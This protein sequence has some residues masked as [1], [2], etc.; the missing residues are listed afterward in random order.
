MERTQHQLRSRTPQPNQSNWQ[1]G[2]KALNGQANRSALLTRTYRWPSVRSQSFCHGPKSS[3]S[4]S[5]DDALSG[6]ISCSL[7]LDKRNMVSKQSCDRL[8][9][10]CSSPNRVDISRLRLPINAEEKVSE[11][12]LRCR[13]AIDIPRRHE[14]AVFSDAKFARRT[15]KF[16][17]SSR[18]Q[19]RYL[20]SLRWRKVDACFLRCQLST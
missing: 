11:I 3:V 16:S 2:C 8:K 10:F 4:S 12:V 6:V 7:H 9:G 19:V 5:I 13:Q 17:T 18:Q 15:R 20:I 1:Y 14:Q